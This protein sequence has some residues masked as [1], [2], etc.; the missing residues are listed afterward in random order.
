[1]ALTSYPPCP[2]S[3]TNQLGILLPPLLRQRF[4]HRSDSLMQKHARCK[5]EEARKEN[6]RGTRS[7]TSWLLDEVDPSSFLLGMADASAMVRLM[8]S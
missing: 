2:T 8:V 5:R 6:E 7:G 4:R 3:E 1:M